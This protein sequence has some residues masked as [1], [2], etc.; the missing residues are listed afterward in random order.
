VL[1]PLCKGDC[2]GVSSALPRRVGPVALGAGHPRVHPQARRS[3]HLASPNSGES[4]SPHALRFCSSPQGSD[5][6]HN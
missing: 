3:V 5:P 4:L 2:N 6:G 1:V